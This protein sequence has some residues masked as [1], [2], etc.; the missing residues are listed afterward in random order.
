M[1]S[2]FLNKIKGNDSIL[3][4]FRLAVSLQKNNEDLTNIDN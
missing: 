1:C 4:Q 2:I 3:D